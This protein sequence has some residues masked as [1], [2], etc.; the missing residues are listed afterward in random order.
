[1]RAIGPA[2]LTEVGDRQGQ[3]PYM[4]VYR[5]SYIIKN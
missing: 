2:E 1:M 3:S 5:L 4:Q